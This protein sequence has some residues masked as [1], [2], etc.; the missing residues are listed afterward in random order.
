MSHHIPNDFVPF[1]G[2]GAFAET[3][4]PIYLR[5]KDATLGFRVRAENCNPVR[6]CHGG[7]LAAFIDMQ[8]P[9]AALQREKIANAFLL[10]VSLS[11]DYLGSARIGDW[12]EGTAS[13]LSH[14]GSLVFVQG[15]V[16]CSGTLLLRGSGVYKI[17]RREP[18]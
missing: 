10:T 11:L 7:W 12:V 16:S 8:M 9:F 4:G 15:L 3:N 13:V 1:A 2:S 5:P 14:T 6:T 18:R 17:A